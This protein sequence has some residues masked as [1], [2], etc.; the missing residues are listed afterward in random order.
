MQ[1]WLRISWPYSD[2]DRKFAHTANLRT[3]LVFSQPLCKPSHFLGLLWRSSVPKP[4][5]N[6]SEY[7][8]NVLRESGLPLLAIFT[9][10]ERTITM[11]LQTQKI[12]DHL[13]LNYFQNIMP[14]KS[15]QC[16]KNIKLGAFLPVRTENLWKQRLVMCRTSSNNPDQIH[17]INFPIHR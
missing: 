13:K 11:N 16:L 7:I 3:K 2:K 6:I 8:Q 5:L 10:I 14:P 1:T 15:M 17:S 9:S 4:Q 12:F